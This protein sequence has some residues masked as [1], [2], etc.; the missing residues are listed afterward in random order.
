MIAGA[1]P[2]LSARRRTLVLAAMCSAL[3]LVVSG[4]SMLNNSLPH[5]SEALGLSQTN[6]QWVVDGYTVALA[7][8]L[9]LAGAMGDRFGRRGAMVGGIAIYGV[10]T[11]L[12]AV[13]GSAGVLIAARIVAGVGAAF[14]MPGTLSTITSVFPP[15]GRAKAVGIWA[16]FAGTGATLG[17]FLS[18]VL[19]DHFYWGSVFVASAVIAAL[20]LLFVLAVVPR[21]KATEATA[22]DPLGAVL[23][24]IGVAGLVIA[25]IEGPERGWT[26]GLTLGSV[27]VGAVFL[28]AFVRWELS[29]DAPMLDPRLFRS[30]GLATGSGAMFL[31]FLAMFGFFFVGVQYL[32]L[33]QGYGA[34]KAALAIF[35]MSA[36][37]LPI[38]PFAATLSQRYGQ[39]AV[40]GAGLIIA[41]LGF[42]VFLNVN[43]DSG[44]PLFFA[45]SVIMGIGM[46]L[47][48]TP[49]TNA[50]VASLPLSRQGV[51]SAINDIT[52]ELGSAFGIA[53]IGS[54]FNMGYRNDIDQHLG[55]LSADSAARAHQA[56]ATALD[57]ASKL[58]PAG[59][60]LAANARDAFVS[61][62]R[63]ALLVSAAAM[64]IAALYVS[65]RAPSSDEEVAEDVI[66]L[67]DPRLSEPLVGVPALD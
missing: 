56:P 51:A 17:M 64:V 62:L 63:Y 52:R 54:A 24:A 5:M 3:V 4:V 47:A 29:S 48:M 37:F 38:S 28:L 44:Y 50:I 6:Q 12:A 45:S 22:L 31:M 11:L 26:S 40:G 20:T 35:P 27:V 1:A 25:I 65:L 60:Q 30:R 42:G 15:E 46:G 43:V 53:T 59:E 49:A 13:A 32:Q 33:V 8:L 66:D 7:A 34:L 61:G 58:G 55:G 14:I 41:A 39:R 2:E 21:T 10:G 9:L 23:S 16:G 57:T 19:V 36:V 18:G 67:D